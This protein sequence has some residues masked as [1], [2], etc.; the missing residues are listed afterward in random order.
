[1]KQMFCATYSN[2]TRKGICDYFY[3]IMSQVNH[4]IPDNFFKIL[5]SYY[6]E[7]FDEDNIE[8]RRAISTDFNDSNYCLNTEVFYTDTDHIQTCQFRYLRLFNGVKVNWRYA[9]FKDSHNVVTAEMIFYDPYRYERVKSIVEAS[10]LSVN[11][12]ADYPKSESNEAFR[13]YLNFTHIEQYTKFLA[14]ISGE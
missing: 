2:V 14:H 11:I 3:K 7:W 13:V 1:M 10:N 9:G 6:T 12:L 4:R 5:L 8:I